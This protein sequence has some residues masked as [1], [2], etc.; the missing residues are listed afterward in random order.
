M[1]LIISIENN[2]D[3]YIVSKKHDLIKGGKDEILVSQG[4]VGTLFIMG[5]QGG[6]Y[7]Y[8]IATK[9]EKSLHAE[10]YIAILPDWTLAVYDSMSDLESPIDKTQYLILPFNSESDVQ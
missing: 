2:T 4:F 1:D 6:T 10:L 7:N 3:S 9:K 5:K 8:R